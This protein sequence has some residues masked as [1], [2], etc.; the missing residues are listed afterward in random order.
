M[1]KVKLI[2]DEMVVYIENTKDAA[3]EAVRPN[4]HVQ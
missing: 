2:A 3:K 1:E 4:K